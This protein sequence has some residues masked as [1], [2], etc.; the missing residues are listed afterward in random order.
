MEEKEEKIIDNPL[1]E[2]DPSR[3]KKE[4]KYAILIISLFSLVLI[5]TISIPIIGSFASSISPSKKSVPSFS[6]DNQTP[7]VY[8][9]NKTFRTNEDVFTLKKE[10]D[11]YSIDEISVTSGDAYLIMPSKFYVSEKETASVTAISAK[12]TNILS[13]SS[14]D[15]IEGIYFP[16][17][18]TS[19]GDNAFAGMTSLKEVKF[20]SGNG[21]QKIADGAFKNDSLLMK[22][23]FSKNLTSIG[24]NSFLSNASLESVDL[25]DT[26]IKTIGDNAFEGCTSLTSFI[27]PTSIASMPKELFK[28]CTSLTSLTYK[29]TKNAWSNLKKDSSWSANS[30]LTKVTCSDGEVAL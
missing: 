6:W 29:G 20:G 16:S 19:I 13:S 10:N 18:Y 25:E 1:Q 28:G 4:K 23:T 30:S 8:K 22:V 17:L 7:G 26:S 3:K 21:I 14:V 2:E 15:E 11:V 9:K 27:L 24:S 5:G 12:E